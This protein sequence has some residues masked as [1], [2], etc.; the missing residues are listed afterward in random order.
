MI[1]AGQPCPLCGALIGALDPEAT[2]H[3]AWHDVLE[4]QAQMLDDLREIHVL[5][6]RHEPKEPAPC[7]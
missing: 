1:V 6:H 5:N 3:Q 4:A 2:L 7:Q